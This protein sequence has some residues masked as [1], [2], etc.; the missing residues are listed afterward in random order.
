[1]LQ[2]IVYRTGFAPSQSLPCVRGALGAPAPVHE[3]IIYE[4]RYAPLY[5]FL[6][7]DAR[8]F[9][10]A[11]HCDSIIFFGVIGFFHHKRKGSGA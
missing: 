6:F 7:F 2:M 3:T 5:T 9:L 4:F 1:M 11:C 8:I 10:A